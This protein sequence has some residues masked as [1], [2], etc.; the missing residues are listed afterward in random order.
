MPIRIVLAD[1]HVVVRQSLKHFLERQ[2]F[3]VVGEA[4][5]GHQAI[6]LTERLRPDVAVLDLSMPL[7]NGIDAA[8]QI[9][10]I[11]SR[12]KVLLLTMHTEDSYVIEALRAGIH[13]YIVKTQI[14]SDV[15]EA[16]QEVVRGRTY[17]SRNIAQAVVQALLGQVDRPTDPLSPRERQVLQL[18]AEGKTTREIAAILEI[19]ATTAASHRIAIMAKLGVHHTADLVR[20]AVSRGLIQA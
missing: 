4:S 1:D 5:D 20:Y 11:S 15:V 12:T 7:L 3:A 10:R 9:L 2:G 19:C 17:L 14:A 18:V 8:K 13:G 6:R 16:I